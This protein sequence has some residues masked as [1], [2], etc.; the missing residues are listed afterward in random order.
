MG[1]RLN[2][3]RRRWALVRVSLSA[4]VFVLSLR[5]YGRSPLMAQDEV[6]AQ[7]KIFASA[8][9]AIE[10]T[11]VEDVPSERLIYSA[12]GG[13]MNTLDPHSHVEDPRQY[14]QTRQQQ[15]GRYYG[16]GVS[17]QSSFQDH[18][19]GV[20]VGGRVRRSG[21]AAS[22]RNGTTVSQHLSG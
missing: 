6:Q 11:Y 15:E 17:I 16:I 9:E 3:P 5:E 20:S 19:S 22:Y 21:V 7:Y 2:P 12:L 18:I 10:R 14:A 13:L 8:L 1:P 4:V